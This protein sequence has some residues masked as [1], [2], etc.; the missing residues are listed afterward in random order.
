MAA[1]LE[2]HHQRLLGQRRKADAP[3]HIDQQWLQIEVLIRRRACQ[4]ALS[5]GAQRAHQ[6]RQLLPGFG[7]GVFRAVRT[8]GPGDRA[9][10]HEG[11]QPF[12]QD[13][14]GDA[15]DAAADVVEAA[16]SAQDFPHDQ[17][18]PPAAQRFVGARHGAELSVSRHAGSLAWR[19]QP[20]EYGFRTWKTYRSK[21]KSLSG[22]ISLRRNNVRWG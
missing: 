4:P 7:E 14:A 13:G 19:A 10:E 6:G 18:G 21:R 3:L 2:P 5:P 9:D 8:V 16:A 17:Q 15:R 20:Q 11:L 1:N 12:G 22:S